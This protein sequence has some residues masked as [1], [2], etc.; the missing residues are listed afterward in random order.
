MTFHYVYS[1][2]LWKLLFLI[3]IKSYSFSR[4]QLASLYLHTNKYFHT[5]KKKGYNGTILFTP[6]RLD[7]KQPISIFVLKFYLSQK[8]VAYT[9]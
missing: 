8:F 9:E 7:I 4:Q 1:L 6:W 3:T 5:T 2:R